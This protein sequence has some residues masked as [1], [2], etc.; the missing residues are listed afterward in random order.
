MKV[1]AKKG[2][3]GLMYSA[4]PGQVIDCPEDVAED[5][6]R[7]GYAEETTEEAT[8]DVAEEAA[9]ATEETTEAT[10]ETTEEATEEATEEVTES[11]SKPT[12]DTGNSTAAKGKS[13]RTKRTG[14]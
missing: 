3:A 9:E 12:D 5:L 7:A 4:A 11:E 2:F 10:E 8:G 1:K 13:G 14:K 6:I